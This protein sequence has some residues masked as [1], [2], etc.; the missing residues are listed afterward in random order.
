MDADAA[1]IWSVTWAGRLAGNQQ[2]YEHYT[3]SGRPVVIIEVGSLIRGTT[4]KMSVNNTTA[5]GYY[6]HLDNLDPDRFA[7]LNIKTYTSFTPKD[8]V[9]IVAQNS[10]SLQVSALPSFDQW[11]L[12]SISKV[13]S[14]TDK[15]IVIR[16]H[17]RSRLNIGKLPNNVTLEIPKKVTGTYDNFDI[18]Y[19]HSAVINY[20]SGAGIQ[21][22]V[23]GATVIVDDSSLAH[24]VSSQ[25][26][27]IENSV[28][29]DRTQW[30]T[31]IAHT[32]YLT[33]EIE[34]GLWVQRLA[35]KLP[36]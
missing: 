9:L 25:F 22:A 11:I 1:M 34:K 32:E 29:I 4:W 10:R 27:D 8:S 21:A 15:P 5:N 19:Q 31:E 7:K 30:L 33:K 14:H 17:P 20:N 13:K 35:P 6:G 16:P 24:P 2:V 23:A 28:Q 26:T 3:K 18:D 12:D 36:L